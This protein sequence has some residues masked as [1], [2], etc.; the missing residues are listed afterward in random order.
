M[1]NDTTQN[2]RPR[3]PFG[4]SLAILLSLMIFVVIPMVVVIFFAASSGILYRIESEAMS[5]INVVGVSLTSFTGVIIVSTLVLI[6]GVAA[7]RVRSEWVRRLFSLVVLGAGVIGSV[8][9]LQSAL[10]G[11]SLESGIDS[12]TEIA[13]NNTIIIIVVLALVTAFSVW[14]MQRW[15][16]KAFYRGYYTQDD[17]ERI[18]SVYNV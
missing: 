14:M 16:A 6:L 8:S 7:W 5:G 13:R 17:L 10:T 3:R 11:P 15:S 12:A 1:N 2:V 18:D 4:V 9:L